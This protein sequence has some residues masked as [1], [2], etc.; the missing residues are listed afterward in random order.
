[1]GSTL[2]VS[3]SL[4]F[5]L[6]AWRNQRRDRRDDEARQARLIVL[7]EPGT[8][9]STQNPTQLIMYISVTNY[10]DQPAYEVIMGLDP[11][12]GDRPSGRHEFTEIATLAP[13]QKWELEF[14]IPPRPGSLTSGPGQVWFLDNAGRRWFRTSDSGSLVR[15][16]DFL[17]PT[18]PEDIRTSIARNRQSPLA[19]VLRR[20]PRLLRIPPD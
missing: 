5:G 14:E 15:V 16:T 4:V 3:V 13:K 11:T 1:M 10:S 17:D 7:N 19:R 20:R 18:L 6:G 2:A 12:S 9:P 8:S